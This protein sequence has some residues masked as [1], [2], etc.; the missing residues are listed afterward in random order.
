M[1]VRVSTFTNII[2]EI[3]TLILVQNLKAEITNYYYF[4]LTNKEILFNLV[5]LEKVKCLSVR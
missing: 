2:K 4:F 1:Y 5:K 3:L